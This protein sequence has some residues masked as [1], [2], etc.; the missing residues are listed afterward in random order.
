M[1]KQ[2]DIK[3][4]FETVH[5]LPR[6]RWKV[7]RERVCQLTGKERP[8]D[9]DWCE[10]QRHWLKQ[11]AQKAGEEFG[12]IESPRF[13]LMAR[14]AAENEWL[15][16]IAEMAQERVG[17]SLGERP[18]GGVIGKVPILAFTGEHL[19]RQH[20]RYFRQDDKPGESSGICVHDHGEIHVAIQS[21]S[22]IKEVLPHEL[23][24][25]HVGNLPLPT[26]LNEGIAQMVARRWKY[27]FT[28]ELGS[29]ARLFWRTRGLDRLWS[30]EAFGVPRVGEETIFAY[31]FSELLVK[32]IRSLGEG[33]FRRFLLIAQREDCG[34][35]GCKEVYGFGLKV[36]AQR[37][38]GAG[39]WD[40][41]TGIASTGD[42]VFRWISVRRPG[43]PRRFPRLRGSSSRVRKSN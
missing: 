19:Y 23:A 1:P 27:D 37:L 30:G 9:K 2:L 35:A 3:D 38:L 4:A 39:K 7:L 18:G 28:A 11:V 10:I 20:V 15:L 43:P 26:W 8:S 36:W 22:G 16:E 25:A 31:I 24:H 41:P 13:L 6:P 5:G 21:L 42:V 33:D 12:V 32:E 14:N 17:S 34:E 29:N 40:P